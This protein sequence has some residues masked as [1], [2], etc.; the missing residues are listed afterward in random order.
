MACPDLYR[1]YFTLFRKILIYQTPRISHQLNGA[2]LYPVGQTQKKKLS[3]AITILP[4]RLR[5]KLF[6]FVMYNNGQ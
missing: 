4:R 5:Y 2:Q 3:V 1:D 6:F